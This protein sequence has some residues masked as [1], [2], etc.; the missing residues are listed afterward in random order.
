MGGRFE[1]EK[2]SFIRRGTNLQNIEKSM[3]SIYIPDNY[4][5]ELEDKYAQY[6]AERIL[7]IFTEEELEYIKALCQTDQSGAEAL[8]VAYLCRPGNFRDL[9]KYKVKPHVFVA[10]HVFAQE[11]QKRLS[12]QGLDIKFDITSF[13][14]APIKDLTT[15]PF[16]SELDAMIKDSDNW[17]AKERYYYIAKMICHASNYGMRAAAFQLNV[18][19]KSRGKIVLSKQEAEHYLSIY[20]GLFPEIHEWHQ[21]IREQLAATKTLYNLFGYPRRFTQELNETNIKEAFAFIPQ[22]TVGCITNIAYTKLQTYIEDT[23]R[24]WDMLA[25]THDSYMGQSLLVQALEFARKQK[26]FIEMK[27]TNFNGESFQMK[28]ETSIGFNWGPW[29][30]SKNTC[31][32]REVKL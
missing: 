7:S 23:R 14:R 18:L 17:P 31:G 32:L 6:Q 27:L 15:L 13:L 26:E 20:H 11:W 5:I 12:G 4:R 1:P 21:T 29:S 28:S 2:Y 30:K 10:M 16:W 8:I 24:S 9:F 22:S 3:R 25:N 19:E